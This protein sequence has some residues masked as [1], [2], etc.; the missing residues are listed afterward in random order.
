MTIKIKKMNTFSGYSGYMKG[1][2][3]QPCD[4]LNDS[5]GTQYGV[6]TDG[7]IGILYNLI[8]RDK[9]TITLKAGDLE[10]PFSFNTNQVDEITKFNAMCYKLG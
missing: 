5:I 3:K 4:I 2:M 7:I 6:R 9:Y 10:Y 1:E 8:S